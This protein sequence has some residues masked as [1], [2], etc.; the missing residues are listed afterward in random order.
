MHWAFFASKAS[1]R[2]ERCIVNCAL[3]YRFAPTKGGILVGANVGFTPTK[4][5]RISPLTTRH[6]GGHCELKVTSNK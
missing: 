5:S 6:L 2:A 1:L 4:V 3:S